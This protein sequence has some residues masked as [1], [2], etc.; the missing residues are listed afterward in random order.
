MNKKNIFFGIFAFS[1]V[2]LYVYWYTDG[3]GRNDVPPWEQETSLVVLEQE[4][5]EKTEQAQP[6]QEQL[7]QMKEQDTTY[8]TRSGTIIRSSPSEPQDLSLLPE[9]GNREKTEDQ[10]FSDE[11]FIGSSIKIYGSKEAA[12][13]SIILYAQNFL[14]QG[15]FDSAMRRFNQA[16][17]LSPERPEIYEG[18]NTILRSQGKYN[19]AEV[20]SQKAATLRNSND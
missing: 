9:Y 15:E 19:Q 16:W 10:I 2:G 3:F 12:A 6:T 17:L 11:R 8:I 13:D 7:D 4:R 20:Y 1:L 14:K 18:Y 5:I